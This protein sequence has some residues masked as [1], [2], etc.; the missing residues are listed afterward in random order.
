MH[1]TCLLPH[2]GRQAARGTVELDMLMRSLF[3]ALLC[4]SVPALAQTAGSICS[5]NPDCYSCALT[6]HVDGDTFRASC[7]NAWSRSRD[8]TVRL[9]GVDTPESGERAKCAGETAKAKAASSFLASILPVGSFL[10]IYKVETDSHG[11]WVAMVR[12]P[13]CDSKA[14][15]VSVDIAAEMVWSGHARPWPARA[16]KP[17][18]CG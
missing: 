16:P 15:C 6:R 14:E 9:F 10:E 13:R 17:G 8:V 1:N 2:C 11:R 5:T 3:V 12:R 7:A 18:W 4:C